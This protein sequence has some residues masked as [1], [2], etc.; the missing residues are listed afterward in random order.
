MRLISP[1][2]SC[3]KGRCVAG[4]KRLASSSLVN[5]ENK[6]KNALLESG[7][8]HLSPER[9]NHPQEEMSLSINCL[10]RQKS[11]LGWVL[12]PDSWVG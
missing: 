4:A 5:G 11:Q 12:T 6:I 10:G 7:S 3:Q 9:L 2:F 8:A 1:N